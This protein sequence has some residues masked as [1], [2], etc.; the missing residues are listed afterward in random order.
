MIKALFCCLFLWYKSYGPTAACSHAA[1]MLWWQVYIQALSLDF[2]NATQG[3]DA[4]YVLASIEYSTSVQAKISQKYSHPYNIS[5]RWHCFKEPNLIA[6]TERRSAMRLAHRNLIL[7]VVKTFIC[8]LLA[9]LS[10]KVIYN[11]CTSLLVSV[12]KTKI[13]KQRS[14]SEKPIN[15]QGWLL[16]LF[17]MLLPTYQKKGTQNI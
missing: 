1:N 7:D 10:W 5:M 13:K 2:E 8:Y 9:I 11:L 17:L 12:C 3:H 16:I 14:I 6:Q 4:L 15:L